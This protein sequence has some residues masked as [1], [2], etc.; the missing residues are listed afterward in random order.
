[1]SHT[2]SGQRHTS[3]VRACG[4]ARF[5]TLRGALQPNLA[6]RWTAVQVILQRTNRS[7]AGTCTLTC[8]AGE[9]CS[10]QDPSHLIIQEQGLC[11]PVAWPLVVQIQQHAHQQWLP[12]LAVHIVPKGCCPPAK[13]AQSDNAAHGAVMHFSMRCPTIWQ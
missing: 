2:A 8:A 1:M 12:R 3:A 10:A 5:L 13:T 9:V 11:A 7:K 6:L 4:P